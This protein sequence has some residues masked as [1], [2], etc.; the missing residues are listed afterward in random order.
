MNFRLA[1]KSKQKKKEES[2]N[3]LLELNKRGSVEEEQY[4]SSR[5]VSE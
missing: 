1:L 3:K 2:I 4:P 5:D